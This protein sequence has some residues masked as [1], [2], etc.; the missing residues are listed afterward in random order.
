MQFTSPDNDKPLFIPKLSEPVV[1]ASNTILNNVYD[2][3]LS[4]IP[5]CCVL[6]PFF[7]PNPYRYNEEHAVNTIP[8]VENTKFISCTNSK[9]KAYLNP[10]CKLDP[11]LKKWCCVFCNQWSATNE[12]NNYHTSDQG[13][14][15][16]TFQSPV[17]SDKEQKQPY[18]VTNNIVDIIIP[19]Q[20]IVKSSHNLATG[21]AALRRRT[22]SNTTNNSGNDANDDSN[23]PLIQPKRLIAR[24]L[25]A[26]SNISAG[27]DLTRPSVHPGCIYVIDSN[28]PKSDVIHLADAITNALNELPKDTYIGLITFGHCVKVYEVGLHGVISCDA[29]PGQTSLGLN[30]LNQ[31]EAHERNPMYSGSEYVSPLHFCKENL[32]VILNNLSGGADMKLKR[33]KRRKNKRRRSV[34]SKSVDNNMEAGDSTGDIPLHVSRT[35]RCLPNA[36]RV[37]L[38]LFKVSHESLGK[39]IVCTTGEI[40]SGR[41]DL[42]YLNM[43]SKKCLLQGI[44]IDILCVGSN[45]FNVPLLQNFVHACGGKV[46]INRL[47]HEETFKSNVV[48]ATTRK[49]PTLFTDNNNNGSNNNTNSIYHGVSYNDIK[50]FVK[51]FDCIQIDRVIGPALT[52]IDGVDMGID[53]ADGGSAHD[54]DATV[55][56][57]YAFRLGTL[58]PLNAGIFFYFRLAEKDMP[59]RFGY[60]QF[61]IVLTGLDGSLRKRVITKRLLFT[62]SRQTFLKSVNCNITAIAIGKKAILMAQKLNERGNKEGT[63]LSAGEISNRVY[64]MMVFFSQ[65]QTRKVV[66]VPD[67]LS[68]IPITL[69]HLLRGPCLGPILQHS[70]D[71]YCIQQLFLNSS[72]QTCLRITQ[73]RLYCLKQEDMLKTRHV[74]DQALSMQ[75]ITDGNANNDNNPIS[76]SLA[77]E[78][79]SNHYL[80][81]IPM[82][83]L[84]LQSHFILILD[85]HTDVFIW[86]GFSVSGG[87]YDKIRDALKLIVRNEIRHRYPAPNIMLFNESDS[88]ARW[89]EARLIPAH[90]D[91]EFL[92]IQ[93]CQALIGNLSGKQRKELGGKLLWTDD[94]SF[95]EWLSH[96]IS[97][98]VGL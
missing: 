27:S 90:K 63:K 41:M 2:L 37:A 82:V 61:T 70:D 29:Y 46:L 60:V 66:S 55:N 67:E 26:T 23:V 15:L 65:Q 21:P 36:I 85:H 86:S 50:I 22:S 76:N 28:I 87:E 49:N 57:K 35:K 32:I 43:L 64:N 69:F 73:P 51:C 19:Y 39:I 78:I 68:V 93:A 3:N 44:S 58:D 72:F 20:H 98:T 94:Y 59:V 13:A 52:N 71:I 84:A 91:N 9:C 77:N 54:D 6:E 96:V 17:K 62:N 56:R 18:E 92:Q 1:F 11:K 31:I 83:T 95:Y 10:Y 45:Y 4:P 8:I 53:G 42:P 81:E 34:N 80:K 40:N 16:D 33:R 74:V 89:F 48:E 25:S 97:G 24:S 79:L 30:E 7:V 75:Q 47:F 88:M 14:N 12:L 38:E 5:F